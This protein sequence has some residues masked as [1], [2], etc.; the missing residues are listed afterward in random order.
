MIKNSFVPRS[1]YKKVAREVKRLVNDAQVFRALKMRQECFSL[2][3]FSAANLLLTCS[4]RFTSGYLLIAPSA[5]ETNTIKIS[6][7]LILENFLA[8]ECRRQE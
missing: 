4:R 6:A 7:V 3:T 1:G 2:S 8:R 5:Q